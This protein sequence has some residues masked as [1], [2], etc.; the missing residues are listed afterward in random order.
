MNDMRKLIETVTAINEN[1]EADDLVERFEEELD[2]L[3]NNYWGFA[4]RVSDDHAEI[5]AVQNRLEEALRSFV[6]TDDLRTGE[7]P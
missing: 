6:S 5:R 1:Y 4:E 7:I 2:T 3:L